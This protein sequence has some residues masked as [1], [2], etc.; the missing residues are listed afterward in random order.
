VTLS[1]DKKEAIETARGEILRRYQGKKPSYLKILIVQPYAI[2]DVV[3]ATPVIRGLKEKY[4]GCYLAFLVGEVAAEVV[5][6]NPDL[7]DVYIFDLKG[8]K[9]KYKT[10]GFGDAFKDLYDFVRMLEKQEFDI[11]VNLHLTEYSGLLTHLTKAPVFLGFMVDAS[12]KVCLTS[13]WGSKHL[14]IFD[15]RES[16]L[17]NKMHLADVFCNVAGIEPGRYGLAMY[18]GD[19]DVEFASGVFSR[20]GIGEDDVVIG[21]NPGAN[22]ESK[23]WPAENFAKLGDELIRR[24]EAKMLLFGGPGDIGLAAS[25][26][27]FMENRPIN[28]AGRTSLKQLGALMA[29]CSAVVANDTGPMHIAAAMK[30]PTV[31]I[32]G[33]T[34]SI[35][36]SPYGEGHEIVDAE[37]DCAPCFQ[38]QCPIQDYMACMRSI[39]VERVLQAVGGIIERDGKHR[40]AEEE[41]GVIKPSRVSL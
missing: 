27:R 16:R 21:L 38:S 10:R 17:A 18:V 24:Y 20:Y 32:F 12:G 14:H 36:G 7:D 33:P 15:S 35:E 37:I 5:T 23:R 29:R 13:G 22:W 28:L 4:P 3:R 25:V 31:A 40:T 30:T 34:Y 39:S 8:Y 11:V 9:E 6:G 2:G 1:P 41:V 19:E 26:E